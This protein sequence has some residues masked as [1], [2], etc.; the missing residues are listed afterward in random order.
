MNRILHLGL[1][2]FFRAHQADFTQDA[3]AGWEIEAVAMRNPALADVLNAQS[4]QFSLIVQHPGG[5][6]VKQINVLGPCHALPRDPATVIA[7]MADPDVHVVTITVT[8]KGYALDPVT[9][10]PRMEDA[11]LVRDLQARDA[12][13]TLLG[14][15][16]AGLAARHTAGGSGLSIIS[17]DNLP[18][19]G[20]LLAKAVTALC[21]RHD[22]AL[23]A[24]V[25]ATCTF[26]ST[27]VDRITPAARDETFATAQAA[28]GRPDPAAIE[29]EPFRQWV[30][31][32]A[33]AGPRPDWAAAGA[34][35][36]PDVRPFEEMKLR[37]LNG[38]HSMIA[39]AGALLSLPAVRDV[40]ART[41]LRAM[42]RWHMASVIPSL[43]PLPGLDVAAYC[44]DLIARFEN[45]AIDHRCLQIAMDGSQK[46]PQRILAPAQDLWA[47]G[48]DTLSCA[49]TVAL[50]LRFVEGRAED[51]T[52]LP[53]DD[54]LADRLRALPAT[55]AARID[56]AAAI[57]PAGQAT[58]MSGS[59][60]HQ[61]V[62]GVLQQMDA[63]GI[64]ATI[65]ETVPRP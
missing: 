64:A 44:D 6:E 3:G 62:S 13:R 61:A 50:W 12:P 55:P 1:G 16:V 49:L 2:A 34:L 33:F 32:D 35:I 7:R 29:T 51:G 20:A 4:G 45:P 21:E 52:P 60:F 11:G 47:E 10:A 26:P 30:I 22:P 53:L 25:R 17:C 23:A 54:P 28:L 31:E 37:L 57:F 41:D 48:S 18:G 5:P 59:G 19:N 14:V 39:Y 8:E 42:V 36:V 43:G 46:L 63:I 58:V 65:T 15:L 40:M 56:G 27:M 24:W 9:G 38:S